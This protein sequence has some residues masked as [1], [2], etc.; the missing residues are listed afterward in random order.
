MEFY[1]E[2][3]KGAYRMLIKTIVYSLT[4]Y[5]LINNQYFRQ[6]Q[7]PILKFIYDLLVFT[8]KKAKNLTFEDN[9]PFKKTNDLT[10]IFHYHHYQLEF[11]IINNLNNI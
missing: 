10:N 9:Y 6:K 8:Q 2:D 5:P 1:P 4:I 7:F 3:V 11:N